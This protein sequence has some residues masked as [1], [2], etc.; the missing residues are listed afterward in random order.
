MH[1][2]KNPD[3][4]RLVSATLA[5]IMCKQGLDED[6][7]KGWANDVTR[8]P[9]GRPSLTV[10]EYKDESSERYHGKFNGANRRYDF[11]MIV[12]A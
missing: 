1:G 6:S 8:S 9:W 12:L 2:G 5:A 10:Q 7:I 4:I 3:E 11:F